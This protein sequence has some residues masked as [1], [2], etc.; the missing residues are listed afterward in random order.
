M[1]LG[2]VEAHSCSYRLGPQARVHLPFIPTGHF[3]N[4]LRRREYRVVSFMMMLIIIDGMMVNGMNN[5][6]MMLMIVIGD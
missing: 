3:I 6:N 2:R 4:Y 1:R 5:I